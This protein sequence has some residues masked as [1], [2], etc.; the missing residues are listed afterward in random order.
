MRTK[1]KVLLGFLFLLG[2]AVSLPV[3]AQSIPIN[4][5]TPPVVVSVASVSATNTVNLSTNNYF[6]GLAKS[7]ALINDLRS[8]SGATFSADY[9][10]G[11]TVSVGMK[12][13][14]GAST[15]TPKFTY[16]F[17]PLKLSGTS[18]I[19]GLSA[20]LMG[21]QIDGAPGLT[22]TRLLTKQTSNQHLVSEFGCLKDGRV[23]LMT[24]RFADAVFRSGNIVLNKT[25]AAAG[26][27][28]ENQT[29]AMIP[30]DAFTVLSK[31]YDYR[32]SNIASR[33]LLLAS[34]LVSMSTLGDEFTASYVAGQVDVSPFFRNGSPLWQEWIKSL[35]KD[36]V[37][38]LGQKLVGWI[39]RLF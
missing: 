18:R 15:A 2:M 34:S 35:V 37:K 4:A 1:S 3:S 7:Q 11:L 36:L 14:Q 13:V 6:M 27:S 30:S 29:R 20:V 17:I 31:C 24:A 28:I 8:R 32:T 38:Q 10:R 39:L 23:N 16:T 12:I 5:T 25:I 33:E 26:A 9:T 19:A 22:Y 21:V